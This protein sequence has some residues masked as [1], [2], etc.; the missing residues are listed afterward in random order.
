MAFRSIDAIKDETCKLIVNGFVKQMQSELFVDEG[1]N[2]YYDIPTLIVHIIIWF[3]HQAEKF[4]MSGHCL[5]INENGDIV[6]CIS[7]AV[8]NSVFGM[9]GADVNEA[10]MIYKWD[11]EIVQL[12]GWY[13]MDIGVISFRDK[14]LLEGDF[15]EDIDHDEG[16]IFFS[17]EEGGHT[18]TNSDLAEEF[19]DDQLKEFSTGDILSIEI[20]TKERSLF[21]YINSKKS[22]K[23][24]FQNIDTETYY[25]ALTFRHKGNSVKIA[26]FS[27]Q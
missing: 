2:P 24:G 27:Q 11:L 5:Q 13:Q 19:N 8:R 1:D 26:D 23:K 10:N 14:K 6:T 25:L 12:E 22:E 15:C 9:C 3:Y 7:D 4:E 20:N 18:D 21:F 16:D 17:I